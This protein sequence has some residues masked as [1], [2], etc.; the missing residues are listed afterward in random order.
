MVSHSIV[1]R[2]TDEATAHILYRHTH[3]DSSTQTHIYTHTGKLP[4]VD[5]TDWYCVYSMAPLHIPTG[6]SPF[7][8]KWLDEGK[9]E[10]HVTVIGCVAANEFPQCS[11]C[12]AFSPIPP[13][14]S[15]LSRSDF[16]PVTPNNYSR[17]LFFFPGL[18]HRSDHQWQ[19]QLF[20][21]VQ[22]DV[23]SSSCDDGHQPCCP[24][25]PRRLSSTVCWALPQRFAAHVSYIQ[26]WVIT[27]TQMHTLTRVPT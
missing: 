3:T 20:P 27:H 10:Q 14:L 12:F 9:Q 11:C 16:S 1:Q 26:A 25:W 18:F 15:V 17:L 7:I 23:P 6:P 4:A 13:T 22:E 8:W 21:H 24:S 2:F 5:S 19:H